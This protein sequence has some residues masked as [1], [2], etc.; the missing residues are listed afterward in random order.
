MKRRITG[1]TLFETNTRFI[2]S[3]LLHPLQ[4]E[5]DHVACLHALY[6]VYLNTKST[7][8]WRRDQ[9]MQEGPTQARSHV[10]QDSLVVEHAFRRPHIQEVLKTSL[11]DNKMCKYC[12]AWISWQALGETPG[13]DAEKQ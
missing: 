10:D 11:R 9:C 2:V 4:D 1:Y 6:R 13:I 7:T 12:S 5:L 3:P 8:Y